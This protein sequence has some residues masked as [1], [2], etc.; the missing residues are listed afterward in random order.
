MP[1]IALI[2][3]VV[4]V[5]GSSPQVLAKIET[6]ASPGDAVAAFGAIWVTNDGSGTLV[7][8]DPRTNRVTRRIRMRPGVFSVERGFGALWTLNYRRGTL[9][10]VNP[11]SG[12][13]RS[14]RLGG[15]P[16]A[17]LAAFGRLWVTAWRA[18]RL[19]V[20]DPRSMRV[21]KRIRTS[22]KPTGLR[23]AAGA[24]W[25][26]F[27]AGTAIARVDPKTSKIVRVPV[28]VQ[29]PAVFTA[30]TRRSLDQGRNKR[31]GPPRSRHP[32]RDREAFLRA[33]AFRRRARPRRHDLGARQGTG[34]HIPGRPE[35]GCGRGLV[36][37]RPGRLL[38]PARQWLDVGDEL[39][40]QRRLAV[41]T[42]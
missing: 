29:A 41:Q 21:V 27:G 38:G 32:D 7:R 22:A 23:V 36:P 35:D 10:R 2:A 28:G 18:G 6:G 34:R 11:V 4:A 40:G 16:E 24:V 12:R 37:S 5:A 42:V 31:R 30:G 15:S 33:H 8:I 17:V 19:V 13:V 3:L 14:V 26:G 39:R 9:A 25:V 20:V 1:K